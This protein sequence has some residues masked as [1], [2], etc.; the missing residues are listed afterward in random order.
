MRFSIL[1]FVALASALPQG[2]C[3]SP[4]ALIRT[5]ERLTRIVGYGERPGAGPG[6]L[7]EVTYG[8]GESMI[9]FNAWKSTHLLTVVQEVVLAVLS[10]LSEVE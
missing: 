10:V 9:S 4:Q 6:I 3:E 8:V 2:P 7:G 1:A 5:G